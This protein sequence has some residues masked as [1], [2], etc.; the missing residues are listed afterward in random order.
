LGA[1]DD[2]LESVRAEIRAAM[3]STTDPDAVAER[4]V[5]AVQRQWAG[6]QVYIRQP[7][8]RKNR[9]LSM[10]SQG[11]SPEAVASCLGVHVS[12]VY[13][14]RQSRSRSSGLGSDDWVL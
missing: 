11:K 14:W 8:D 7:R 6:E 1:V 10:L 12:S 5:S 3:S 4:V 13:R 9:A 2:I